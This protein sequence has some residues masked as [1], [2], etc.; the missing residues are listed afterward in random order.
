MNNI[1][2]R[3]INQYRQLSVP[4]CVRKGYLKNLIDDIALWKHE[5]DNSLWREG[6]DA[7]EN[8]LMA[9][10]GPKSDA[11]EYPS[12]LPDLVPMVSV[13]TPTRLVHP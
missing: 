8:E 9:I 3:H 12:D 4:R 2:L 5:D 10:F 13:V 7:T 1:S 6:T 11:D